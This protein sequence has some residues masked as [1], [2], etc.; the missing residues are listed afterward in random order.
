MGFRQECRSGERIGPGGC[1]GG[2]L[3]ADDLARAGRPRDE[4]IRR[5]VA[6]VRRRARGTPRRSFCIRYEAAYICNFELLCG[7]QAR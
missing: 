3:T 4:N 5:P 7:E 6:Y 1:E 2:H